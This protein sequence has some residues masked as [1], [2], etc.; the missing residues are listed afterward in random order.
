MATTLYKP[1][2]REISLPSIANGG[3]KVSWIVELSP[4]GFRAWRKRTSDKFFATWT[5]VLG[6]LVTRGRPPERL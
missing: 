4:H 3:E 5:E 2:K 6:V 1:I